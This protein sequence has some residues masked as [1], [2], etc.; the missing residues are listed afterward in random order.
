MRKLLIILLILLSCGEANAQTDEDIINQIL[1]DL[2]NCSSESYSDTVFFEQHIGNTF[3][4]YDSALMEKK[5]GL[6]I[7]Q[8]TLSEIISNSK[9]FKKENLWNENDLNKKFTVIS[10]KK[11]TVFLSRKPYIKC[12]SKNQMDS[13]STYSPT[14]SIYALTQLVFDNNAQTA[15]FEF[16]YGKG[17]KYF[18]HESVLIRKIFNRWTIVQKFDWIIS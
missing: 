3:F 1:N 6:Q 8:Q 4:N 18:S 14:T 17:G 2:L 12:L 7:P 9:E 5:T 16:A 11:G 10:S 13:I 15:V